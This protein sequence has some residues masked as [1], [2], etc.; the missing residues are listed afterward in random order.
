MLVPVRRAPITTNQ[1]VSNIG[2]G[3]DTRFTASM[4]VPGA[5]QRPSERHF[6]FEQSSNGYD[7]APLASLSSAWTARWLRSHADQKR[8]ESPLI[9]SLAS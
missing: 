6:S 9:R 3:S 5:K 1:R 2:P 4:V 8:A 7:H